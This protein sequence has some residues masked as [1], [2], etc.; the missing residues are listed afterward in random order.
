M[1]STKAEKIKTINPKTLIV[2]NIENENRHIKGLENRW[3][4]SWDRSPTRIRYCLAK[5]FFIN[6]AFGPTTPISFRNRFFYVP[7]R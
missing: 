4:R 3:L 5:A 2:S 1:E 6:L 7:T